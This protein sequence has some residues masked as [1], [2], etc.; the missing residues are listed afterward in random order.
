MELLKIYFKVL[1][2]LGAEKK[3]AILICMA[4]IVLALIT[5]A[6]PILF[7]HVIYG[8][9]A[10]ADKQDL[11]TNIGLWMGFG[12]FNIIAYVLVARSA[13]RLAHKCRIDL[14]VNSFT[15]II[16]M[17]IDWHQKKGSSNCL[18]IML[19]ACDSMSSIWLDFMRQHLSTAV[20]LLILIPTAMAMD[21][22][23]SSIL[24]VLAFIYLMVA[25]L[26]MRKT[27]SGQQAVEKNH[28]NVFSHICD[29]ITNIK[30]VQ[31][32]NRI[33]AESDTLVQQADSLLAAQFPVLNWW[34]LASGLN[35]MASTLSM[36]VVLFLG[37]VLVLKGQMNVGKVVAFVGFA[38]L[39]ISRLD[40]ISAF[41][42]LTI[43]AREPLNRFFEIEKETNAFNPKGGENKLGN[44]SGKITFNN[45]TF[46]HK[47]SNQ[48]VFD[49][50][51]EIEAGQTAAIVGPTGAGKTTIINLLQK[52]YQPDKGKIMIDNQDIQDVENDSLRN[53]LST[54]FQ[55]AGLFNRSIKDNIKIGCETAS[56]AEIIDAA[57]KAS[58]H[59]FISN[60]TYGYN[61]KVGEQGSQLSGGERQRLSIAR[62][63]LKNA[64]ILILD[65]ATS[66]LDMETENRVKNAINL[67]SKYRTTIII[68]HRLSTIK[69]A[70]VVFFIE[71]GR[72]I[73]SGSFN[74]LAEKKGRF[75]QLLKAA[76][77]TID[78][79]EPNKRPL[80]RVS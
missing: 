62:A 37:A 28:H 31:S 63:I 26:I 77:I 52:I 65:E 47:E 42:N 75:A 13:D 27:K 64:P 48:G 15:K 9:S 35:R 59:E 36:V 69:N 56:Y 1:S 51:F 32:Y 67:V 58:A 29:V 71:K 33:K 54:V 24:A 57:A 43:A 46:Q 18:H 78:S 49:I 72:I 22:R 53:N 16:S 68:A 80:E 8:I 73:E 4:N 39:M 79:T 20:A 55:E 17:P 45:V 21:L 44:I 50:S 70:D 30:V 76:E 40:Q 25:R 12:I 7:G 66:A 5:I 60:K 34:A 41:I 3:A 74:E 61:T 11:F 2:Y 19:R 10:N 23:L 14:L 6:E 38:Q